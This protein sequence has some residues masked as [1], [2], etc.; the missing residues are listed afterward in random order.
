MSDHRTKMNFDLQSFLVGE[1]EGAVQ[2]LCSW[3]AACAHPGVH[4]ALLLG[5]GLLAGVRTA[6]ACTSAGLALCA[7]CA[8]GGLSSLLAARAVVPWQAMVSLEQK[9]M[10]EE[11][12]ASVQAPV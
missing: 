5:W 1:I 7:K 2:V 12:A 10:L 3:Q 8:V 9:E 11:L 4:T 6:A